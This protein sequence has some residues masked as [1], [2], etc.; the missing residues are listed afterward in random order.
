MKADFSYDGLPICPDCGEPLDC[1][2]ADGRD[3]E[4]M[5]GYSVDY[6]C[7]EKCD[8]KWEYING[9]LYPSSS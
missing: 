1:D 7:C 5:G 8:S 9:N 2:S 3:T 4:T 6:Y